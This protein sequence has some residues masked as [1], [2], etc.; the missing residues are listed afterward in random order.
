M[1]AVAGCLFHE[2]DHSGATISGSDPRD[3]ATHGHSREMLLIR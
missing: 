3:P 1:N 2:A